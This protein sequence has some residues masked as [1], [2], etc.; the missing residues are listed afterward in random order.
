[1]RFTVLLD[2]AY[3]KNGS[4]LNVIVGPYYTNLAMM[5]Q[6]PNFFTPYIVTDYKGFDWIDE[7]SV[8]NSV[9]WRSLLYIKPSAKEVN[10]A[11]VD[12]FK[13]MEWT[14]AFLIEPYDPQ[15]NQGT[16]SQNCFLIFKMLFY[17]FIFQI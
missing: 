11:I 2:Y 15:D 16:S 14:S 17:R 3:S 12:L 9:T 13:A 10:T 6:R 1:M 7:N 8:K 5:T 4:G